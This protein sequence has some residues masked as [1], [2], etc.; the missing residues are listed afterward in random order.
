MERIGIVKLFREEKR[1]PRG[2][3]R[4]LSLCSLWKSCHITPRYK[5][6]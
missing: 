3:L 2:C 1:I 6:W 5:R 4:S